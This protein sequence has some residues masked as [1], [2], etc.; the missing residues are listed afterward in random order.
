[1]ILDI[2][3]ALVIFKALEAFWRYLRNVLSDCGKA[4]SEA[5]SKKIAN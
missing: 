1:M 5:Y 3:V 4:A 2:V